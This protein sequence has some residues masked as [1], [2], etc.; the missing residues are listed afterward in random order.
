MGNQVVEGKDL[1]PTVN[2]HKTEQW[3]ARVDRKLTLKKEEEEDKKLLEEVDREA[4]VCNLS[5]DW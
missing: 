3:V 1:H 2:L 5:S 4:I